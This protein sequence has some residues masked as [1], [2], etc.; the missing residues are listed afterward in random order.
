MPGRTSVR[1][2]HG[3]EGFR[4]DRGTVT[5]EFAM[6]L[7]VMLLVLALAVASIT[8]ATQR[9]ALTS[10]AAEVARLEARGDTS[11]AATR[12]A[13][14]GG[15]I[16]STRSMRGALHCVVLQSEPALGMLAWVSITARG[17]AALAPGS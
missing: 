12:L 6:V 8:L 11:A 7:P 4:S 5:A 13:E 16:S 17:C 15:E 14:L 1:A 9:L 2:S 3:R 10:A